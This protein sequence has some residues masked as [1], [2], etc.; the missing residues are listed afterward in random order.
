LRGGPGADVFS[1]YNTS[2]DLNGDEVICGPGADIIESAGALTSP[3]CPAGI[4]FPDFGRLTEGTTLGI[5]LR[6]DQALTAQL[7]VVTPTPVAGAR[8]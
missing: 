1:G 2:R 8:S 7:R 5:E 3:D 4:G 6:S